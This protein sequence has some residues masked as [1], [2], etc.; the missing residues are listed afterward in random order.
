MEISR[1]VWC[2]CIRR[3]TA[4]AITRSWFI[5][6]GCLNPWALRFFALIGVRRRPEKTSRLP[7]RRRMPAKRWHG[8]AGRPARASACGALAK[9]RGPP[10]SRPP[11][12]LRRRFLSPSQLPGLAQHSRCVTE[13][14]SSCDDV[15]LRPTNSTACE[16]AMN[17]IS[18][19]R[20]RERRRKRSWIGLPIGRG[21][22]RVGPALSS[23][24][25][26]LARHGLRT[27]LGASPGTL[28]SAG[29]LDCRGRMGAHRGERPA[30]AARWPDDRKTP[31]RSRARTRSWPELRAGTR[32]L[33]N[34]SRRVVGIH[35]GLGQSRY[36][37]YRGARVL[38]CRRTGRTTGTAPSG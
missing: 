13:R 22:S 21:R 17:D 16:Q 2:R 23:G 12:I 30:L 28:P 26:P 1:L 20:S 25:W 34:Q 9:G 27:D 36:A 3:R 8:C 32:P 24:I 4:L 6:S 18:G 14:A 19:G 33:P 37:R 11:E 5:S 7:S 31:S 35:A 15:A 29:L 38:R 10:R